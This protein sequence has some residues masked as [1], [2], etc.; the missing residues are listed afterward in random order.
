MYKRNNKYIRN[1]RYMYKYAS[2]VYVF[3]WRQKKISEAKSINLSIVITVCDGV[4][5]SSMQ[6]SNN[7]IACEYATGLLS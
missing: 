1:G 5:K 3:Y 2:I 7:G 6:V 4:Y